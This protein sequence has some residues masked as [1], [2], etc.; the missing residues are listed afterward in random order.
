[1]ASQTAEL[2]AEIDRQVLAVMDGYCSASGKCRTKLVAEILG[3]WADQKLH[4]S[5]LVCRVAGVN[6]MMP[7]VKR[8]D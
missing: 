3:A 5:T 8:R 4:E 6:P 1:M 7:E 2:R